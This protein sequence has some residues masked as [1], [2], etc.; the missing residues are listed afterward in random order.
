MP[1]RWLLAVASLI[2]STHAAQADVLTLDFGSLPSAQGWTYTSGGQSPIAESSVWSLSGG[3]LSQNSL[4]AG[5]RY[6]YYVNPIV[7]TTESFSL[8]FRARVFQEIG[9]TST[10]H[11]AF[12]VQVEFDDEFYLITLAPG[13]IYSG[14]GGPALVVSTAIDT[15]QFH[16]YLLTGQAETHSWQLSVDGVQVATGNSWLADVGNLLVFG[17]L[18]SGP[19]ASGEWTS[20]VFSQGIA[21][22]PEPSSFILVGLTAAGAAGWRWRKR[23]AA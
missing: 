3:V 12:G 15:T 13:A 7:D 23:R 20:L 17:D 2:F 22:V 5:G 14:V 10:N 8:E 19:N 1:I 4:A 18:T 16:T 11:F 6:S 21:P 9:G